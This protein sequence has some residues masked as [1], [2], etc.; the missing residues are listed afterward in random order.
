MPCLTPLIESRI[1]DV[2]SG[3]VGESGVCLGVAEVRVI[4]AESLKGTVTVITLIVS[5]SEG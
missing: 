5:W 2:D 4:W 1:P 3:D